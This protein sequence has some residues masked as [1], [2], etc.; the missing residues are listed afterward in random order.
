MTEKGRVLFAPQRPLAVLLTAAAFLW[1]V[2]VLVAPFAVSDAPSPVVAVVYAAGSLVCHQRPDRSFHAGGTRLPVC[3]R[4]A[5]LYVAG[6]AGALAAWLAIPRTP[7]RKTR[8]LLAAAAVPTALTLAVEWSGAAAPSNAARAIAAAPLGFA[9][10]WLFV[11]LL[12]A[13]E[14]P[15]TCAIIS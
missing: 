7:G 6:A 8:A 14:A 4:C 11:R 9:A 2:A 12:R 13:E 3:A 1:S 15:T 5:G 10:G